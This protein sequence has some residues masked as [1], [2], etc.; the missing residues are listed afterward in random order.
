MRELI[1][2]RH[3]W[4]LAGPHLRERVGPWLTRLG[5]IG[6]VDNDR[7]VAA[8]LQ[9][10]L[11]AMVT[12]LPPDLARAVVVAFGMDRAYQYR[13]LTWRIE[14]LAEEQACSGRTARRRVDDAIGLIV[15]SAL[16]RPARSTDPDGTATTGNTTGAGADPETG[17]C[18]RAMRS[19]LR[20]DAG[21][22]ELSETRL[23]V[24]QRG[25]LE[26]V[27]VRL[28]APVHAETPRDADIIAEAVSGARIVGAQ[29]WRDVQH[30]RWELALTRPLGRGE[31]HEVQM[32]YRFPTGWPVRPHYVMLP[33]VA[34]D[35][36]QVT[37]AFDAHRPPKAVW[38]IDGV[39]PRM[40]DDET[41]GDH[42]L[43]VDDA[44]SVHQV[45]T[46][47]RQGRGYGLGWRPAGR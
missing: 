26:R 10:W 12:D 46:D 44:A 2:L 40:L 27:A 1:R 28:S 19:G 37:V 42:P 11:R 4:G 43:G 38:R 22:V 45:F 29:R 41:P 16:G 24:A 25:G 15:Q 30:F 5:G 31:A 17:W 36:F 13:Q 18:V 20:F 32:V 23:I 6:A 7:V 34:C 39:P 8:K 3:G 35:L 9:A 21:G 14:R 47:L 33:L